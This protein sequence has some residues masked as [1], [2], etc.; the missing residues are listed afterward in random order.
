MKLNSSWYTF[1]RPFFFNFILFETKY[2]RLIYY[3]L[4]YSFRIPIIYNKSNLLVYI[5]IK[6][7]LFIFIFLTKDI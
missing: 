4:F 5:T 3:G 1:T 7:S 6:R 2:S